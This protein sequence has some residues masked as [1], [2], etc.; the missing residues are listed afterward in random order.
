MPGISELALDLEDTCGERLGL[1]AQ[2]EAE[3]DAG[4]AKLACNV[5]QQ[6][7]DRA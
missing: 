3:S 4:H 7:M 2:C 1:A 5:L 6:V